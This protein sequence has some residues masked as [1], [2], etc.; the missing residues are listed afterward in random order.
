MPTASAAPSASAPT[1]LASRLPAF[2]WDVLAP[3]KATAAAHPDGI[4]D[5]SVGTPVDPVPELVRVALAAAANSPGYPLTAGTAELRQAAA[6]WLGRRHGVTVSPDAV[7]PV[8][9]TKEFIAWLPTLLGCGPE[10][11]V[12][13]PELAYPTYEIGARLA[14][15][16]PAATDHPD[17]LEGSAVR[18]AWLNS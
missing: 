1:T 12:C 18:L 9:G 17:A 14:G 3:A 4:V 6:D 13:Y 2:P 7:L 5:L 8:I 15:A 11:T 16:R 10:S